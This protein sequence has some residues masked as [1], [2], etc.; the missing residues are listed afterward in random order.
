[1]P[2]AQQTSKQPQVTACPDDAT[3]RYLA[4]IGPVPSRDPG[5]HLLAAPRSTPQ[6]FNCPQARRRNSFDNPSDNSRLHPGGATAPPSVRVPDPPPVVVQAHPLVAPPPR[7]EKHQ[8]WC[9]FD[10]HPFGLKRAPSLASIWPSGLT[11]CGISCVRLLQSKGRALNNSSSPC[12]FGESRFRSRWQP[13]PPYVSIKLQPLWV[14]QAPTPELQ[15]RPSCA[16]CG[17]SKH[18]HCA[19]APPLFWE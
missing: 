13:A 4:K 19:K 18:H 12:P 14:N 9:Q 15:R 7:N 8:H 10:P 2:E 3:W 17:I 11:A 1:M 16:P 5:P 6:S